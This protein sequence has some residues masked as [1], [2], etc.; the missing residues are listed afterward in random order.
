MSAVDLVSLGLLH[1]GAGLPDVL[2]EPYAEQMRRPVPAAEPFGLADGWGLGLALFRR[3][4]TD[5]VG[6]DGNFDGTSCYLRIAANGSA[7][8]A[9]PYGRDCVPAAGCVVAFTSNA[10]TGA[11]M[12]RDLLVELARAE[13]PIGP[14]P[15]ASPPGRP[16]APPA[17]C[18]GTY[19]NGEMEFVVTAREGGRV[20]L[21]VDGDAFAALTFHDGLTFAV[22]DPGSGQ[23][24]LGGR[25]VRDRLTGRID[26]IHVGGRFARRRTRATSNTGRRL[27]A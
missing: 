12:W 7:R 26:G 5:H 18:T 1:L 21:A 10:N 20:H 22:R 17:G 27:I 9:S 13:L 23:L 11:G 16:V 14:A 8:A 19:A 2:A 6:H 3:G 25:F 24:V 4:E 15:A